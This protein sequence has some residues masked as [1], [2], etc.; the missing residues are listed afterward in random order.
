MRVLTTSDIAIQTDH[1]G[2]KTDPEK[3]DNNWT[4][5]MNEIFI[6]RMAEKYQC[7]LM[8][9]HNNWRGYLLE[10]NYHPNKLLRDNIHLNDHGNF[11][12]A[13]LVKN[14]LIANPKA[15][16]SWSD[17][18]TTYEINRDVHYEN[19]K[20][21]LKFIGNRV[22]AISSLFGKAKAEI[23]ID[24]KRPSE[25]PEL[26]IFTRPNYTPKLDWPWDVSVP[27]RI[28]WQKPPIEEDWKITIINVEDQESKIPHF[29]FK[30]TGTKTGMDGIGNNTEKFIS[31]SGRIVILPEYW[32][33]KTAK[34][35]SSPIKSGYEIKFSS[36]LL[37]KDIYQK[38]KFKGLARKSI[39]ILAQGLKNKQHTLEI[40]PLE[41][42]KVPI[43]A[44]R[45]YKPPL[46]K[47]NIQP[48]IIKP[49]DFIQGDLF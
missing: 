5:F 17:T 35:K 43:S 3:P 25:I 15:K 29:T 31:H 49:E 24:S 38:P 18:V 45:I 22:E 32:W 33:L 27:F 12:M 8:D 20:L 16:D 47:T 1:L 34:G 48:E 44:I 21:T 36:Q 9:V 26:Y 23:L 6:P 2:A 39:V 11:L 30:L 10:N 28:D 14:Y 13:E 46:N 7:E 41:T 4:S 42:G 40:I 37:G 19:G